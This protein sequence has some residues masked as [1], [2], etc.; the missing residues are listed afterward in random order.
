MFVHTRSDGTRWVKPELSL[1][2]HREI[3]LTDEQWESF[4]WKAM[5]GTTMTDSG[6][7]IFLHASRIYQPYLQEFNAWKTRFNMMEVPDRQLTIRMQLER[8][9]EELAV[10]MGRHPRLGMGR[11]PLGPASQ[12]S[13]LEPEILRLICDLSYY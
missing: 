3:S 12:F 7:R 9:P 11:H 8:T 1:D 13:Q 4:P 6:R 10:A 2:D 5:F